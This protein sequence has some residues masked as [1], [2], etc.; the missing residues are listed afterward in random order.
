MKGYFVSSVMKTIRN[1][2]ITAKSVNVY[3]YLAECSNQSGV[4]WPS[5]RTI[6]QAC[7]VSIPTVT[8]ALRELEIAGMIITI[9]RYELNKRQTSNSYMVFT[10]PQYTEASDLQIDSAFLPLEAEITPDSTDQSMKTECTQMPLELPISDESC[11]MDSFPIP[12]QIAPEQANRS[13]CDVNVIHN[14]KVVLMQRRSCSW[15]WL[16]RLYLFCRL[17][18]THSD[19]LPRI[20]MIPHGTSSRTKVTLKQ[21]KE[22]VN[23]KLAKSIF[24]SNSKRSK[25][26]LTENADGG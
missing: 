2:G 16:S 12:V 18:C 6:A 21:R 13:Q 20:K 23:T 25:Y 17:L 1:L 9:P 10:E 5:K 22:Q 19:M 14:R 8:R 4:T 3:F 11:N 7:K 26:T 24:L 15:R